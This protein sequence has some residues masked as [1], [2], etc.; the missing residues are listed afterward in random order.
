M[1]ETKLSDL[2]FLFSQITAIVQC[3]ERGDFDEENANKDLARMLVRL[4]HFLDVPLSRVKW[5][6]ELA[7]RLG[8]KH[9]ERLR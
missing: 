7:E 6:I 5:E 8:T 9:L 2:R 1:D 4:A 3:R